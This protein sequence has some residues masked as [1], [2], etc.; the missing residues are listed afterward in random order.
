MSILIQRFY[1]AIPF[2]ITLAFVILGNVDITFAELDSI[3]PRFFLASTF[4]WL[5]F[6][7]QYLGRSRIIIIALIYDSLNLGPFG[8]SVIPFLFVYIFMITQRAH[9]VKYGF[10]F[11]WIGFGSFLLIFQITEWLVYLFYLKQVTSI[12]PLVFD[13]MLTFV[14]YP[15]IHRLFSYLKYKNY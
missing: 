9:L 3:V 12:I 4:Y 1:F 10:R 13:F 15:F 11:M 2:V 5:L 6:F 7:P 14:T 8:I